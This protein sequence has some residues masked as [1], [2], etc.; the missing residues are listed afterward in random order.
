MLGTVQAFSHWL[1]QLNL[2]SLRN[3]AQFSLQHTL[4]S[5]VISLVDSVTPLIVQ[6]VPEKVVLLACQCLMSLSS[7]VRPRFAPTLPAIQGLMEKAAQG[8]LAALPIKV[9]GGM[10]SLWVM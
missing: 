2:D 6:G 10:S 1:C 5:L 7:T 9:S 3:K 8:K 4:Q